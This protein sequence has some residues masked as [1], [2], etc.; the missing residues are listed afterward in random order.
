MKALAKYTVAHLGMKIDQDDRVSVFRIACGPFVL[1]HEGRIKLNTPSA[2]DAVQKRATWNLAN[3][4]VERLGE[5]GAS[6][7]DLG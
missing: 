6:L 5:R 7:V 4:L 2:D 1:G 3:G